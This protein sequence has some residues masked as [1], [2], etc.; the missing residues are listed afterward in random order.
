[1]YRCISQKSAPRL[2]KGSTLCIQPQGPP[3]LNSSGLSGYAQLKA[4][5][6]VVAAIISCP[7]LAR[8]SMEKDK[9]GT[10]VRALGI[11]PRRFSFE[12]SGENAGDLGDGDASECIGAC[13][14]RALMMDSA[15]KGLRDPLPL[16]SSVDIE[17]AQLTRL[18]FEGLEDRPDLRGGVATRLDLRIAG[19]LG[20]EEDRFLPDL[21]IVVVG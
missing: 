18:P 7:R 20:I 17:D 19:L 21:A 9:R 2:S 4:T 15:S 13:G 8:G 3:A 1:L 5:S 16:T 14:E 12:D 11:G 6:G 10:E